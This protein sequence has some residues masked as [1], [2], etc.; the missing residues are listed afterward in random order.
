[1]LLAGALVALF[2][3][4]AGH[5]PGDEPTRLAHLTVGYAAAGGPYLYVVARWRALDPTRALRDVLIV[6]AVS[7]GL[8]LT[9]PPLLS[10]DLWRYLWDGLVQTAGYSPYALA[11]DSPEMRALGEARGWDGIRARI[12]HAHIPTIYPPAAQGLFGAIAWAAPSP[13]LLRAILGVADLVCIG[14]LGRW[15]A[16][17]HGD[18]RVAALY[19][20]APVA[21]LEPV[22]GGHVDALG[23]AAIVLCGWWVSVGRP[24]AAG[25]ALAVAAGTKLFPA[26]GL[27]PLLRAHP[28]VALGFL[29]VAGSFAI[30]YLGDGASLG[31]G[32]AA[33]AHRWRGNEGFFALVAAP[34][35]AAVSGLE[36][37]LRPGP[38]A[39]GLIRALVGAPPNVEP[40]EVWPDE[41]AFAAAKA[42]VGLL[43]ACVLA[44]S[45]WRA[46][47]LSTFLLPVTAALLLLSPVAHPWYL[48]WLLPLA[49]LLHAEHPRWTTP[50]LLWGALVWVAYLPRPDYLRG[51]GWNPDGWAAWVQYLPV[52]IG[53]FVAAAGELQHGVRR[54]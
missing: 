37:P 35:E 32:L 9:V 13:T 23:A 45:A 14:V 43:F 53:L 15:A 52:W 10:E 25:G 7:R 6:A 26:L 41:I 44:L 48:L 24:I 38:L 5:L 29:A 12:G 16:A 34:F 33:Y 31:R 11:P 51:L 19:A 36:G 3:L 21:L 39:H 20:F 46:R 47:R 49:A 50:L 42:V 1:V 22:V 27:I 28:R 2:P 8:L 30:L 54:G 40:G 4:L 17:T 18:A